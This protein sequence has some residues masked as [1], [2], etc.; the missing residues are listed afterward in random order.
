VLALWATV[1]GLPEPVVFKRR[2]STEVVQRSFFICL[3]AFLG[4]NAV[5][6]LLL[7]FEKPE[8][9]PTLFETTSAFGTVGLSMG[10]PGSVLSLAGH[11]TAFGKLLLVAMMFA[12]RVGPLT[13]A[14]ALAGR[15]ER[16]RFRY[17]EGKVAIG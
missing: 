10:F 4:V 15:A 13:L 16:V 1:R 2:F 3:I 17:P 6:A 11:M 12:G 8:L 14:I 9:L 5:A 7:V